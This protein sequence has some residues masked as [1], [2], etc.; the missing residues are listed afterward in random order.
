MTLTKKQKEYFKK[1][2]PYAYRYLELLQKGNLAEIDKLDGE[3]IDAE[4][5]KIF[6]GLKK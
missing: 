3:K 2:Y 4:L 5:D 6:E 1:K